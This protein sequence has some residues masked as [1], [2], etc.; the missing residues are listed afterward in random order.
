MGV[1]A[2]TM[3]TQNSEKETLIMK[4]KQHRLITGE[5]DGW[6]KFCLALHFREKPC[7]PSERK[8]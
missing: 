4:A 1:T 6:Y 7:W 3:V 8:C 5:D 2:T